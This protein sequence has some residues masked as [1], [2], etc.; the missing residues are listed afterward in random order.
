MNIGIIEAIKLCDMINEEPFV[1][2]PEILAGGTVTSILLED[3]LSITDRE[4]VSY[5][6]SM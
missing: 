3:Y 1:Q 4:T 5:C 2:Q 6:E